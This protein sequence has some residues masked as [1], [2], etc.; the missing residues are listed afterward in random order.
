MVAEAG[1]P[2]HEADGAEGEGE[3]EA[4]EAELGLEVAAAA[5]RDVGD[6]PVADGAAVETADDGADEVLEMC[7]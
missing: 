1:A 4:P 7:G 6:E 2:H 3:N 5:L